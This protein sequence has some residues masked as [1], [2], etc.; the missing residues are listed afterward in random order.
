M[1]INFYAGLRSAA[2]GKTIDVPISDS[3]TVYG[4]LQ[5]A[6]ALKPDLGPEIFKPSGEVHD[7]IRVLVNGRDVQHLPR[8]LHT[9]LSAEDNLDVFPPVGG[10]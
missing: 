5:A 6:T 10:G 1:R 3:G 8:G 2:G 4:A 9:L 7:H